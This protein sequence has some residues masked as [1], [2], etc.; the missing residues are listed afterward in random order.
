MPDVKEL[1]ESIT[2]Q[3]P[4]TPDALERQRDRQTR[5]QRNRKVGGLAL[6]VALGLLALL[7][8]RGAS[9]RSGGVPTNTP[10]TP[11]PSERAAGTPQVD[12]LLDLDTGATTALP[13]A[14]RR[15]VATP[16]DAGDLATYA[17]S[18][19]G[20]MIAFVGFDARVRSQIFVAPIDGAWTRQITNDGVGASSPAW[21]PDGERVAFVGHDR[22]GRP[23]LVVRDVLAAEDIAVTEGDPAVVGGV[24]FTPDGSSLLYIAR[25]SNPRTYPVLRRVPIAGGRSVLLFGDGHGGMHEVDSGSMSPDGRLVTM[26]GASMHSGALVRFVA[27][28]DG[29]GLRQLPGAWSNPAGTWSPGGTR[30]VC[31]NG[32]GGI[33]VVDVATG[34]ATRVATGRMAIWLD[35]HTLLVEVR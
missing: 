3:T 12:Y 4:A 19:D 13:D 15:Q 33:L 2:G 35:S 1:Y 10:T 7:A 22:A 16:G 14:I 25:T 28:A 29:K 20:S 26:T 31:S 21:S 17:A 11:A 34:Q 5:R 24:Q 18:P 23:L 6:V 32:S 27:G 9:L 8:L 30:I